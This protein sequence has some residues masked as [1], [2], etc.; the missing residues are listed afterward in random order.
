MLP[1]MAV[2]WPPSAAQ[3][4]NNGTRLPG[5][6]KVVNFALPGRPEQRILIADSQITFNYCLIYEKF[7]TLSFA[8]TSLAAG[9]SLTASAVSLK[10]GIP[11]PSCRPGNLCKVD[12]VSEF[13]PGKAYIVEFWATWCGRA[14]PLFRTSTRLNNKFKDKA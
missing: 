4:W 9:F 6:A 2:C 13:A 12:A 3:T 7:P 11:R 5:A 10:V 1:S 14:E 8:I